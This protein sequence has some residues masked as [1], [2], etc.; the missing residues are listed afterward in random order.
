MEASGLTLV[1]QSRH[2]RTLQADLRRVRIVQFSSIAE[3][4]HHLVR[5][6]GRELGH[7]LRL[8]IRGGALELD[9]GML[10]KLNAPLEHL[11][12]NAVAHGIEAAAVRE[13]AGKPAQGCLQ[14]QL[15][16]QA[17]TIEVQVR[18]DGRGLNLA[19]I[20]EQAVAAGLLSAEASPSE[21]QL[22]ALI[23]EPGLSTADEVTPLSGR[24]IGMDIVRESVLAQGG[25]LQVASTA[26]IGTCFTLRLPLTLA[27]TQVVLLQAARRQLAL[28]SAMV[29]HVLQLSAARAQRARQAAQI[30]WRGEAVPLYRL[31]A[32]LVQDLPAAVAESAE[33]PASILVLHGQQ[34]AVAIEV[35]SILGNREVVI[36]NSGPQLAKVAGIA[37][38]TMLA[39]GSI[40]L[41]INPLPLIGLATQRSCTAQTQQQ[42]GMATLTEAAAPTVLV[43]DDSLTVRRVSER[44]LE[45]N[46]YAAVLARDGLDALEKLQSIL[47]AAILLDIEMPRMDGFELLRTLRSDSRWQHVPVVMITS[48]TAS[49]HHDHAVQLG[50]NA[51]LGK[52]YQETELLAWLKQTIHQTALQT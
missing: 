40:V 33:Q 39:D 14:L 45:R 9:R 11:L 48:R 10:E 20:R 16:Q 51:Y 34:G 27:T 35:D 24:G 4:L 25:T 8:E 6:A 46:G 3:R 44:L 7:Q 29:Q 52:P 28:P 5:Q 18:D 41:I 50:A 32:L 22:T 13:A 42:A 17:N 49:K 31:A 12:R 36:K 37:G 47:P 19:R 30:D 43:V 15:S 26:G 38:A 2:A 21:E 1:S 23:F